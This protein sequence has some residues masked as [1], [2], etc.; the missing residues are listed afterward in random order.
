MNDPTYR[1]RREMVKIEIY[2]NN[3]GMTKLENIDIISNEIGT[4]LQELLKYI[5]KKINA[6]IVQKNGIFIRKIENVEQIE[7]VIEEY[8]L[9]EV[10]CP[11]CNNPE[12]STEKIKKN[13]YKTCKAC[14][15]TRDCD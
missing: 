5:K 15:N 11:K 3:G 13:K 14:G 1:Y 7:N 10:L 6:N 8:I 9:A 2:N 4:E 12:F